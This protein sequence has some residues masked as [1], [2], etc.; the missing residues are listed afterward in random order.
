MIS[1]LLF[2]R[3]SNWV[4][5]SCIAIATVECSRV[6]EY[7]I[8]DPNNLPVKLKAKTLKQKK[9][10]DRHLGSSSDSEDDSRKLGSSKVSP[11][12]AEHLRRINR[13]DSD[14]SEKEETKSK[15]VLVRPRDIDSDDS[16][17]RSGK[18]K[19]SK[20]SRKSRK[21]KKSRKDS[22]Q[23][24]ESESYSDD[25][26]GRSN[27]SDLEME[28]SK[29]KRH[30]KVS[31]SSSNAPTNKKFFKRFTEYFD[32]AG[33][34]RSG[35]GSG[36]SVKSKKSKNDKSSKELVSE[37]S[38]SNS[39]SKKAKSKSRKS[40][41][42]KKN[43][44]RQEILIKESDRPTVSVPANSNSAIVSPASGAPISPFVH[45]SPLSR[46][47][48]QIPKET[49]STVSLETSLSPKT[50]SPL[51]S[52]ASP[53]ASPKSSPKLKK[54]GRH[55]SMKFPMNSVPKEVKDALLSIVSEADGQKTFQSQVNSD[56]SNVALHV[57]VKRPAESQDGPSVSEESKVNVAD[58]P[59]P[60]E[61]T[62]ESKSEVSQAS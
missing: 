20:K 57:S 46:E 35:K 18:S 33:G 16:E 30:A 3:V 25:S 41:S 47:F 5:F 27:S 10:E 26:L 54:S 6:I 38:E 51:S 45:P 12:L 2:M 13:T 36:K 23:R 4:L 58:A 34:K 43:D 28:K 40:K 9:V 55:Y 53:L 29:R 60:S 17:K 49:S 42:Q 50:S 62:A 32:Y 24:S 7:N 56:Y 48:R 37:K 8:V 59:K 44:N 31:K 52:T 21:M 22:S 61:S 14:D 15:K 1:P 39:K 19:K 11:K